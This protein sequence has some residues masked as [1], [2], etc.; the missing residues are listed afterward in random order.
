[1]NWINNKTIIGEVNKADITDSG[2]ETKIEKLISEC[3]QRDANRVPLKLDSR[4]VI[5]VKKKNN[6]E[7]YAEKKR[8]EFEFYK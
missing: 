3:R 6:N 4:T 5:L 1:M 2:D 8:E 7:K